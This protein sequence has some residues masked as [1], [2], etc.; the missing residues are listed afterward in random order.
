MKLFTVDNPDISIQSIDDCH[1]LENI[2]SNF[3]STDDK[4]E[5]EYYCCYVYLLALKYLNIR[6]FPIKARK[7]ERPD[8]IIDEY[9]GLEHTTATTKNYKLI[10]KVVEKYPVEMWYDIPFYAFENMPGGDIVKELEE[11]N[12]KVESKAWSEEGQEV[13]WANC[14]YDAIIKKTCKVALYKE[15]CPY[16][17]L[18]VSDETPAPFARRDRAIEILKLK[19]RRMVNDKH[20]NLF[21][22]IHII[23]DSLFYYDVMNDGKSI[24][25]INTLQ[26]TPKN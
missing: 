16:V 20:S 22:K 2:V 21:A 1:V 15:R 18:I 6:N 26:N 24:L 23:S 14:F 11:T 7:D 10:S 25:D 4:F 8:F 12:G 5:L 9:I 3:S 13:I 17:E 19:Y